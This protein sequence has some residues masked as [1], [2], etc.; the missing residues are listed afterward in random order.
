MGTFAHRVLEVSHKELLAHAMERAAG[1]S[2]L[3]RIATEDDQGAHGEAWCAEVDRLATLAGVD[4]TARVAGSRVDLSDERALE[5]ARQAL[6]AEFDAHLSHQYQL[7]RGR[8]PLPQAL[9]AHTAAERGQ[10]EALRRDLSTLLDYEAGL[11][12]GYEPRLFEWS[13]GR[14]GAEV[15]YAGVRLTGT[16]DRVDVDAHGQA[17]VIDYKHKSDR[18]FA[19]EYD[20]FTKEGATA[21]AG[22]AMPRRVQSLIYGQV[23]RH[24]FPDL[25]VTGAV[26]LCTKGTHELAGAVGED[27]L[28]NVFGAHAPSSQRLPRLAVPRAFGFGRTDGSGMEALLDACE[29]AIAEQVSRML[30]GDVQASPKDPESCRFCPVLNCER[31]L[32]K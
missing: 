17:V 16:V 1:T 18:G 3:E 26:Y 2:E 28:D 15:E 10:V 31:R 14:G 25:K 23:I 21:T 7:V 13:F 8:R 30:A 11:L 9:V 24:A 29:E 27:A 19:A 4:P 6:L 32:G 20:V 12:A 5:V 22:F